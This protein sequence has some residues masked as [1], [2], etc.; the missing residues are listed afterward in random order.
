MERKNMGKDRDLVLGQDL[1]W[2]VEGAGGEQ[3]DV[4]YAATSARDGEAE[5][6]RAVTT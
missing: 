1:A 5:A 2:V 4:V 3:G 6:A